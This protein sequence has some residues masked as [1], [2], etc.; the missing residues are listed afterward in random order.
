M[1]I[2][3]WTKYFERIATLNTFLQHSTTSKHFFRGEVDDFFQDIRS[4]AKFPALM[5]E[6]S[7][8]DITTATDIFSTTRTIA[9]DI[10]NTCR[11][12][13]YPAITEVQAKC[14]VVAAAILER[15]RSDIREGALGSVRLISAHLEPMQNVPMH[16]YGQ[17]VE[18]VL[19]ETNCYYVKDM[20]TDDED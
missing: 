6:S 3:D 2:S 8:I 19:S 18:V 13:D 10:V 1:T 5:L 11:V 17:R 14:E 15:I 4:R 16:Y 12:D 20:W 9:F 7:V